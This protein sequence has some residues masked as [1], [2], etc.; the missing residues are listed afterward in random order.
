MDCNVSW[1]NFWSFCRLRAA[2]RIPRQELSQSEARLRSQQ[3]SDADFGRPIPDARLRQKE[4]FSGGSLEANLSRS[5]QCR[6]FF[7]RLAGYE[8]NVSLLLQFLNSSI[9]APL[10]C[11]SLPSHAEKTFHLTSP[12]HLHPLVRATIHSGPTEMMI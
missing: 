10:V 3:I 4:G 11:N 12:T 2:D 8:F 7:C 6:I 1:N 5:S 9:R